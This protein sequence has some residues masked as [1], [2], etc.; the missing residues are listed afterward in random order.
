MPASCGTQFSTSLEVSNAEMSCGTRFGINYCA[1][2][3][4]SLKSLRFVRSLRSFNVF[5]TSLEVSN[6]V[7]GP[8]IGFPTIF[9]GMS[10]EIRF[11]VNV[12]CSKPPN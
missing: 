9:P 12:P 8:K 10:S 3:V 4:K 5:S 2:L 6:P 1:K 7:L 11:S